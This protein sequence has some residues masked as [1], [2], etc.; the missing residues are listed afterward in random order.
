MKQDFDEQFPESPPPPY[1]PTDDITDAKDKDP[2]VRETEQPTGTSD[3][4]SNDHL[5]EIIQNIEKIL[6]K[7]SY[8]FQTRISDILKFDHRF[9]ITENTVDV[10]SGEIND[11]KEDVA[12]LASDVTNAE[13]SNGGLVTKYTTGNEPFNHMTLMN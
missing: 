10:H 9:E 4:A 1:S 2:V 11:L 6:M 8:L 3:S 5:L 7:N 13:V 12:K